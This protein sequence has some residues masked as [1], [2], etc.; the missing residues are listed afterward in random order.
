MLIINN[1][2]IVGIQND[3]PTAKFQFTFNDTD[4]LPIN[5]YQLG[6]QPYIIA[7]GS[8]A[9]NNEK[10][11][12]YRCKNNKWIK[13]E[14]IPIDITSNNEITENGNYS[15]V[16]NMFTGVNN[17]DVDVPSQ[18]P[19]LISKSITTNGIY[20]A[21]DDEA[22]GYSSVDVE[23]ENINT[24]E[25]SVYLPTDYTLP[26]GNYCIFSISP[27]DGVVNNQMMKIAH[28]PSGY[29]SF[30]P[31][32]LISAPLKKI[33]YPAVGMNSA[34]VFFTPDSD[35]DGF[36]SYYYNPDKKFNESGD[37]VVAGDKYIY[38]AVVNF[39]GGNV[40]FTRTSSVA[41]EASILND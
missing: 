13:T 29:S 7:E 10:K 41:H 34:I 39:T 1:I 31:I 9:T 32:F 8:I 3:I 23:V 5:M 17:V 30:T 6:I 4:T 2:K 14:Y 26:S 35:Y 22:D 18:E 15:V 28:D 27:A 16:S 25:Y 36:Y 40:T 38:M 20:N 12:S 37:T 19:T 33:D 11:L 24:T 21:T